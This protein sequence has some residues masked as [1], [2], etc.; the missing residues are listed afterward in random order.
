MLTGEQTHWRS[1]RHRILFAGSSSPRRSSPPDLLA[2]VG[3]VTRERE[4]REGE[5]RRRMRVK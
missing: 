5:E 3:K 1:A 2:E 4:G